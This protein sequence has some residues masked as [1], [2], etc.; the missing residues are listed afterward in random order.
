MYNRNAASVEIRPCDAYYYL[1]SRWLAH[2]LVAPLWVWKAERLESTGYVLAAVCFVTC[3]LLLL[4]SFFITAGVTG[5]IALICKFVPRIVLFRRL[6]SWVEIDANAFHFM[7]A[8]LIVRVSCTVENAQFLWRN[9]YHIEALAL[10]NELIRHDPFDLRALAVRAALYLDIGDLDL[11]SSDAL[12][13]MDWCEPLPKQLYFIEAIPEA[14][15]MS[16]AGINRHDDRSHIGL[17]HSIDLMV[18]TI[19]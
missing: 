15:R 9:L 17:I 5:L 16:P 8:A 18:C 19:V 12:Q 4:E 13:V 10:L 6:K 1:R 3:V 2:D 14:N 11:A 7:S